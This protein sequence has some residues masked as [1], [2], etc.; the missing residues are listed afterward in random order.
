MR[1]LQISRRLLAVAGFVGKG[2]IVADIGCDHGYIPIYLLQRGQIPKAI[3]MDVNEDP[4]AGKSTYSG[5]GT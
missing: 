4:Y 2:C 3:A 5:V 1:E